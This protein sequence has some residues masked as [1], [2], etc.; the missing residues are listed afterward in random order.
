M[1]SMSANSILED[2][3]KCLDRQNGFTYNG[4]DISEAKNKQRTPK[5]F[6]TKAETALWFSKAFGLELE[7][8]KV[9][10]SNTG[11][12]HEVFVGGS[13][14]CNAD[15]DEEMA[16]TEQILY[17]QDKFCVS[18]EFCHELTMV[19]NGIPRSYLVK[20]KRKDLNKLCHIFPIP[21]LKFEGAQISFQ[22]LLPDQISAFMMENPTFDIKADKI[23]VKISGDGAKMTQKS[24]FV[25]LFCALLQKEKEVMSAKGN[26]TVA[27]FIGSEKYEMIQPCFKDVFSEI[28]SLT[29]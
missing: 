16:R 6:M 21:D 25:I 26:H 4:K 7:S 12:S 24:N 1:T 23:K 2:Y 14:S 11:K 13:T 9:K 17:L 8:I 5:T 3:S 18:D 15:D 28:N 22:S 20:Q 10:E 29:L 19:E 27:V